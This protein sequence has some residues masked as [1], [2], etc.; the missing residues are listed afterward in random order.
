MN[1]PAGTEFGVDT[2][3]AISPDGRMLAF[4][5][6][7]SGGTKLWVRPLNSLSA[8]ELPGTDAATFPFWS[9][10]GRSLGFF[11]AGKLKRIEV[12]GGLPTVICDVGVGTRWNVE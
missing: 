7:S 2:G 6:G 4:V 11:A 1:P 12:A 9:P 5:T 3:A 10:D 8:R